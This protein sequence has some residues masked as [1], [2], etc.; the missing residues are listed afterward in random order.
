MSARAARRFP[1]R[2]ANPRW[3]LAAGLLAL[4]AGVAGAAVEPVTLRIAGLNE[5]LERNVRAMLTMAR[6]PSDARKDIIELAAKRATDEIR[7][8]LQP[9]GYYRP[10]IQSS[11]S[12]KDNRW[13]AEYLSL[14]HI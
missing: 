7:T 1:S 2:P 10:R 4:T 11:L 6:Q 14:I 8:A 3:L 13:V 12:H 9:F 5:A